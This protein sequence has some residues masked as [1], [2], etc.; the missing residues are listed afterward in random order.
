VTKERLRRAAKKIKNKNPL[1]TGNLG[2]RIFKLD[3]SNIQ[4]WEVDRRDL[5]MTLEVAVKHLKTDR[6]EADILY[7]L[8]LKLGLD[9]C[10]PIETRTIAGK[11]VHSIGKGVLLVCLAE[12]IT[13]YETEPLASGMVGWYKELAPVGD[14]TCVFRDSGFADDVAKSNLAAILE[15]SGL[16][17]IRSI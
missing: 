11:T 10:V 16:K 6:S 12:Q 2:F 5:P 1:F 3:T 9:L 8:L 13:R 17:N 15:Q 14:T 7:E 4:A